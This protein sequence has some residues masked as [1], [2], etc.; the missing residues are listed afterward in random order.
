LPEGR[1]SLPPTGNI[2]MLEKNIEKQAFISFILIY[3]DLQKLGNIWEIYGKYMG[4]IRRP[5][6]F[7]GEDLPPFPEG[8]SEH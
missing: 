8:S 2:E 3:L 7:A 6:G 1:V 5:P 4:N